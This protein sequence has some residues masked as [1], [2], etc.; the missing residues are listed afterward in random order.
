[1]GR[2]CVSANKFNSRAKKPVFD[3]KETKENAG[4]FLRKL[5]KKPFSSTKNI[6]SRLRTMKKIKCEAGI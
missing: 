3:Y 5:N 2:R 6:D 1:V 4:N